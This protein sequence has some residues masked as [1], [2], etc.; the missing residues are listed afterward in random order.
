MIT[1]CS[2]SLWIVLLNLAFQLKECMVLTEWLRE[3]RS[4]LRNLDINVMLCVWKLF[5]GDVYS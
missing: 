3:G 5:Q 4:G 1:G 2:F